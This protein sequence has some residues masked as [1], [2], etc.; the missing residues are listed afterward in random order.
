MELACFAFLDGSSPF[1]LFLFFLE[2][3][4]KLKLKRD[5][6]LEWNNI[7]KGGFNGT[8]QIANRKPHVAMG[9]TILKKILS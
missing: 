3:K 4:L 7:T 5:F 8:W 2:K 9:Q 6:I 1:V